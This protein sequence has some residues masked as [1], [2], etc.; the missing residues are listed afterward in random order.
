VLE[1]LAMQD[2]VDG[3]GGGKRRTLGRR[4]D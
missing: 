3:S 1:A 2:R 4:H